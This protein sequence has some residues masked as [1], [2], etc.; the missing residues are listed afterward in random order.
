VLVEPVG[1]WFADVTEPQ[2]ISVAESVA[3]AWTVGYNDCWVV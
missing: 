2:K 3:Y 1:E